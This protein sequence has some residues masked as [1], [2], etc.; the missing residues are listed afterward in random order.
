MQVRMNLLSRLLAHTEERDT[1]WPLVL[2][3]SLRDHSH[4][5]DLSINMM[6]EHEQLLILH[7]SSSSQGKNL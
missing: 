6:L 7:I 4:Y 5:E 3:P 1:V 2:F